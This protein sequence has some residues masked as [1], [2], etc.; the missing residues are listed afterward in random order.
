MAEAYLIARKNAARWDRGN[1]AAGPT[2]TR[3]QWMWVRTMGDLRDRFEQLRKQSQK[4]AQAPEHGPSAMCDID[5]AAA[6]A[7]RADLREAMDALPK[8]LQRIVNA[9]YFEG[10]TQAQVAAIL[11]V[12]QPAVSQA[13]TRAFAKMRTALGE[14]YLGDTEE[15]DDE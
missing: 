6:G 2:V 9:I 12:S 3:D 11:G 14:D 15:S 8:K 10:K 13:L 4:F 7:Q 1:V 5:P